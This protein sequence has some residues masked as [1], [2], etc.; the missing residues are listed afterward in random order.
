MIHLAAVAAVVGANVAT[1]AV[2]RAMYLP[3][4]AGLMAGNYPTGQ[5]PY[6]GDAPSTPLVFRSGV[7]AFNPWWLVLGIVLVVAVAKRR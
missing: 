1:D 7:S 2:E 6:I 3:D 4:D 5:R